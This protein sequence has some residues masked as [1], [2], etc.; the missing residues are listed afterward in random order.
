[1][2]ACHP[3]IIAIR[4]D[5]AKVAQTPWLQGKLGYR[6]TV[7]SDGRMQTFY[8]HNAQYDFDAEAQSLSIGGPK[9]MIP[10]QSFALVDGNDRLAIREHRIVFACFTNHLEIQHPAIKLYRYPDIG[11]K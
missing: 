4:I 3:D 2:S 8:I 1:M 10:P 11:N 6:M 5:D 7:L 9:R